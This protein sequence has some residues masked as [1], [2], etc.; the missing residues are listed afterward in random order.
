M[1]TTDP[2]R[3]LRTKRDEEALLSC[4][5]AVI[6][7]APVPLQSPPFL[8]PDLWSLPFLHTWIEEISPINGA[9]VLVTEVPAEEDHIVVIRK[10]AF[11]AEKPD[12]LAPAFPVDTLS[13]ELEIDGKPIP[14]FRPTVYRCGIL[15]WAL[16]MS[17]VPVDWQDTFILF[18]P[19]RS[20]RLWAVSSVSSST[21]L[22]TMAIGGFSG[23]KYHIKNIAEPSE[24][25]VGGAYDWQRV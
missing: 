6:E 12:L 9:R 11:V 21:P 4:A 15:P 10:Y 8:E 17:A 3:P 14:S 23:W 7:S 13:F 24:S 18:P 25:L 19:K 2:S 1:T 20:L 5:L 22:S 16:N